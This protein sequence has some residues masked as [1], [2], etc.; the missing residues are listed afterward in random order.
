VP[1]LVVEHPCTSSHYYPGAGLRGGVRSA[2]LGMT[3][4]GPAPNR[5]A[6]GR[7][8]SRGR[9]GGESTEEPSNAGASREIG[10]RMS[11]SGSRR[12]LS[13]GRLPHSARQLSDPQTRDGHA[14]VI[15]G[16][17]QQRR[18]QTG[19]L[20]LGCDCADFARTLS[21]APRRRGVFVQ[22]SPPR[23]R[24]YAR[25]FADRCDKSASRFT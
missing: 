23:G 16:N 15:P 10:A 5:Q 2:P 8:V 3:S 11:S 9:R 1:A 12:H 13:Y 21:I 20:G 18:S 14:F 7:D 22:H 19:I 17:A 4:G 6:I 25:Y 24:R